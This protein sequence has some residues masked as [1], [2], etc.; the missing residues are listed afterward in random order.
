MEADDTQQYL[1]SLILKVKK[2]LTELCLSTL[3]NIWSRALKSKMVSE[4]SVK[5]IRKAVHDYEKRNI[6]MLSIL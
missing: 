4:N 6:Q 1:I 5:K 2:G 3:I